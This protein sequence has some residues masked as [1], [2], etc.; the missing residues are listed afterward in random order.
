LAAAL[1][2][3]PKD[4]SSK[5]KCAGYGPWTQLVGQLARLRILHLQGHYQHVL[6]AGLELRNQ[7]AGLSDR[8]SEN[9]S[10][11]NV[12]NVRESLLDTLSRAARALG[13][14]QLALDFSA[15]L[16]GLLTRRGA[17]EGQHATYEVNNYSPLL[18]L[19]RIADARDLLIRCREVFK[20]TN[21]IAHLG[22]TLSGLAE[23]EQRLDHLDRAIDLE[24]DA[25]RLEY[26][27]GQPI[28]IASSHGHLA[29]ILG[30]TGADPQHIAAHRLAAAL[31][32]YQTGSG[33]L[34]VHLAALGHLLARDAAAVP[35]SFAE[36]CRIVDQVPG[37]D[38][39]QL[40]DRLP[41]RA[42]DP[43]TAVEEVLRLASQ[44]PQPGS[45][46][47]S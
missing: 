26:L 43:Q 28:A 11:I 40:L 20:A 25:L 44:T 39:A 17:S 12:W 33:K 10:S 27:A 31:I 2:A 15:E 45:G 34:R 5:A 7:A 3:K 16:G 13:R 29:K 30:H 38:L 18:Q 47:Y 46:P 32:S 14:W 19:D 6:D 24:R 37:V 1:N 35:I 23:V 36:L 42:R 22:V 41:R 4:I 21:D 8:R 9:D